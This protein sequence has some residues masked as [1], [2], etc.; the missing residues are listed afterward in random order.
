MKSKEIVKKAQNVL[1]GE[2]YLGLVILE[3]EVSIK[4]VTLILPNG[5]Y[6]FFHLDEEVTVGVLVKL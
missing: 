4:M 1:P 5:R 2:H 6:E 3:V